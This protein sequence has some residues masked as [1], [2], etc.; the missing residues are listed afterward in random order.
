MR[1]KRDLA[2]TCGLAAGMVNHLRR[3]QI[4]A[5]L[6]QSVCR[7]VGSNTR[8]LTAR[9]TVASSFVAFGPLARI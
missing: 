3:M 8:S 5:K 1:H 6:S 7:V 2:T 4:I 9:R